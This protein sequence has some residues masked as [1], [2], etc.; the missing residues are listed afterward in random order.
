MRVG[1]TP[2]SSVMSNPE[3]E[4]QTCLPIS[5]SCEDLAEVIILFMAAAIGLVVLVNIGMLLGQRVM[6]FVNSVQSQHRPLDPDQQGAHKGD[7]K[8]PDKAHRHRKKLD[9][10][11]LS[12]GNRNPNLSRAAV[13]NTGKNIQSVPAT[14]STKMQGKSKTIKACVHQAIL[15]W[16]EQSSEDSNSSSGA[17]TMVARAAVGIGDSEDEEFDLRSF[18]PSGTSPDESWSDCVAT[19]GPFEPILEF[20]ARLGAQMPTPLTI[21]EAQNPRRPHSEGNI[22]HIPT[23]CVA[24]CPMRKVPVKPVQNGCYLP[25]HICQGPFHDTLN[26]D[27]EVMMQEAM[28]HQATCSLGWSFVEGLML[29]SSVIVQQG[30][31]QRRFLKQFTQLHSHHYRE[32]VE[33]MITCLTEAI[34]LSRSGLLT[35]STDTYNY[36]L[37]QTL[38]DIYPLDPKELSFSPPMGFEHHHCHVDTLSNH[39]RH[40]SKTLHSPQGISPGST[41][42]VKKERK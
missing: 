30:K 23:T 8:Q 26:L 38:N 41:F 3:E 12:T 14:S 9:S 42:S 37:T 39:L 10:K 22:H 34:L 24:G 35:L 6:E 40:H 13:N 25:H 5:G 27:Q 17:S 1:L 16:Q 28:L 15:T 7:S 36:L 18:T 2:A 33:A 11:T 21:T 29:M 19:K 4:M 31:E 32:L 20:P